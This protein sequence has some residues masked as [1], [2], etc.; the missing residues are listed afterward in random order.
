MTTSAQC[1]STGGVFSHAARPV[2]VGGRPALCSERGGLLIQQSTS[3]AAGEGG[4]KVTP[5]PAV[6]GAAS[7]PRHP[8]GS[9]WQCWWHVPQG[10]GGAESGT[11]L[12]D[13]QPLPAPTV[14][15][16]SPEGTHRLPR[17]LPAWKQRVAS[18]SGN[19]RASTHST[20]VYQKTGVS[21]WSRIR[22]ASQACPALVVS[23]LALQSLRAAAG[24]GCRDSAGQGPLPAFLFQDSLV[25]SPMYLL[26]PKISNKKLL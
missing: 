10:S 13:Q 3:S 1:H 26:F 12:S 21:T 8:L 11:G 6:F 14:P 18:P 5:G 17:L 15:E 7:G 9:P 24:R 20:E 22:P 23:G 2:P 4:P 25:F 19:Y 16:A